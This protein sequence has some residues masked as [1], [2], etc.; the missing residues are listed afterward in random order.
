MKDSYFQRTT[1]VSLLDFD[2]RMAR[3]EAGR[4]LGRLFS[5]KEMMVKV[6]EVARQICWLFEGKSNRIS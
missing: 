6:V 3:E 4:L 5:K 1:L 2:S